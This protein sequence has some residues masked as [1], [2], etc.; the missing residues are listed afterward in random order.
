MPDYLDSMTSDFWELYEDL[1]WETL[2]PELSKEI[3][4]W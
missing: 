4:G 3:G 2:D 1:Y